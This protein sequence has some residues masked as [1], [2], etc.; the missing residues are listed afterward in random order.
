MFDFIRESRVVEEGQHSI[1]LEIPEKIYMTLYGD[2]TEDNARYILSQYLKHRQDDGT[3]S[4]VKIKQN[5]YSHT[6]N[7]Y[8]NLHYLENEKTEQ[9]IYAKGKV[10][11]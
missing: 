5:R 3:V 9:E 1:I 7:I 10:N 2:L 6:V 4:D 11:L 8:A